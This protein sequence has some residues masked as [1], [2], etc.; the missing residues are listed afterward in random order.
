MKVVGHRAF[1]RPRNG[2]K[3]EDDDKD[4]DDYDSSTAILKH[5]LRAQNANIPIAAANIAKVV[6]KT[7]NLNSLELG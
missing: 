7:T 3:F 6:I 4:E 5:A 2:P 1:G